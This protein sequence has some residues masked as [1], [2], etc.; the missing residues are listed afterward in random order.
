MKIALY[1]EL[2][3]E[4]VFFTL[5]DDKY[6]NY[7]G[8]TPLHDPPI[9]RRSFHPSEAQIINRGSAMSNAIRINLPKPVYCL[10]FILVTL[11]GCSSLP[12]QK[13]D[14]PIPEP[15]SI[16]EPLEDP[17][18]DQEPDSIW[19]EM[20]AGFGLP[21]VPDNRISSNLAWITKHQRYME[22]VTKQS[23]PFLFYVVQTLKDNDIPLELALIPIVES[24]YNP[25]AK[26]P[27]NMMGL[28]QFS[29]NTGRHFGLQQNALYD[30]RRDVIAS[31]DA[32]VRYLKYLNKMF[33]GDWLLTIAAYNSGEGRVMRAMKQNQKQGKA[34][35]FWSLPLPKIT[36][37]YVP[38]VIALSK[39]I[40]EPE[41]F[42]VNLEPIS[43]D[44]YFTK[45]NISKT[46]NMDQAAKMAD[47]DPQL[48]R[49]L[50]AGH[51]RSIT[52]PSAPKELVVPIENLEKFNQVLPEIPHATWTP[53]EL[54]NAL[55]GTVYQ[56]KAGDSLWSI[57]RAHKTTVKN[58][59][60]W[61]KLTAKS[62]IKP[63]QKL[64]IS[65]P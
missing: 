6:D 13:T 12:S 53:Q 37:H 46:I 47:I 24:A 10:L 54:D 35:D 20:E 34:T 11:S 57:A 23:E 26:S 5:L 56:V 25:M 65:P 14:E 60:L 21:D 7:S 9:I 29:S 16:D 22:K 31:T 50:N 45:I 15:I 52:A 19:D 8:L 48:M 27:S 51:T 58:I 64:K 39:V 49:Q 33:D 44:P 2:A 36:K 43:N 62:V 59:Q 18:E 3:L 38:Q 41:K 55:R 63:G 17:I 61:N 32:A 28:W 1:I 42:N 30:G 40:A 4:S